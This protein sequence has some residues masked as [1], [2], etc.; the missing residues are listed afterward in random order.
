MLGLAVKKTAYI[1]TVLL[2]KVAA[3]FREK[4]IQYAIAYL[5]S[6]ES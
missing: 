6:G 4:Q 1:G 5:T 2:R 3:D